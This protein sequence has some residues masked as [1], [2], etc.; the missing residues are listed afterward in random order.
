MVGILQTNI[1]NS[2]NL[3]QTKN[4]KR[5]TKPRNYTKLVDEDDRPKKKEE[6]NKQKHNIKE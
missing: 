4:L 6:E 2:S 3:F 1:I 5:K